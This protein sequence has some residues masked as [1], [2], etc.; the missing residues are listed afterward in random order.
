MLISL[1]NIFTC[2]IRSLTSSPSRPR[3]KLDLSYGH[4][5]L[6]Q[7]KRVA[8]LSGKKKIRRQRK[9]NFKRKKKKP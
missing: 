1:K 2:E 5:S 6:K 7:S 3:K 8:R 4:S 9:K